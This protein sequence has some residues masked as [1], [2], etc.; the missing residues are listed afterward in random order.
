MHPTKVDK[1]SNLK[2]FSVF[3]MMNDCDDMW[4]DSEPAAKHCFI[5]EHRA[6][7]LASRQ[8]EV[9]RNV[10]N[11]LKY[12]EKLPMEYKERRIHLPKKAMTA[13]APVAVTRNDIDYNQHMNNSHYIRIALEQLPEQFSPKSIRI[14]YKIPAKLG[15]TLTPNIVEEDAIYYMTLVS[16]KGI[17]AIMEFA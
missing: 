8:V 3:Q 15:D 12:N 14:E 7:L 13:L 16:E 5:T 1:N 17:C 4:L 6:Q 10:I 2:L 9:V 11:S